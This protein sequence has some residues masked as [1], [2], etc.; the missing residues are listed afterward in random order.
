[1]KLYFLILV[2]LLPLTVR[3]RDITVGD[4]AFEVRE[5][6]GVPRGQLHVGGREL[7]YFDRGEVE[8]HD[9][10]VTRVGLR[11]PEE[12]NAFEAKQVAA[13]ARTDEARNRQMEEGR[14]LM[15]TKQSDPVF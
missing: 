13:A 7:L 9:G 15:A 6:M 11:S 2:V 4:S 1:M 5:L 14:A 10:R 3:A 12:Q 8:L